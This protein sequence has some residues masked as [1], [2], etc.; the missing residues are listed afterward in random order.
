MTS[1]ACFVSPHGFGHAARASAVMEAIHDL[2]SS[3]R[4]EVFTSVPQWFFNESL[5]APFACHHLAT[6]IGLVQ[7][8]PLTEN[9]EATVERL[10]GFL[11]FAEAELDRLA[12][13]LERL[14]CRAVLC[15]ISPLG[16]ALAR[17]AALPSVLVENFTWD[18]IYA[19]YPEEP[20]LALFGDAMA[21]LNSGSTLHIQAG[22]PCRPDPRAIAVA[23]ISRR[24]RQERARVRERLGV[25]DS[26]PL[27]LLTMGGIPWSYRGMAP[28]QDYPH[29]YFVVPGAD[30]RPC[31][32]GRLV[33][34]PHHSAFYHPDLVHAADVAVGKLGYSTVAEV[35]HS[36]ATFGFVERPRFPESP[37]LADF[38]RSQMHGSEIAAGEFADNTWLHHLDRLLQPRIPPPHPS[39]GAAEA[40]RHIVA[41]LRGRP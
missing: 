5:T 2:D 33:A 15:D 7:R 31:R 32:R 37:V 16:L 14:G 23:P 24:P 9:L 11:P 29:A 21:E 3:I 20:R 6:D 12:T 25:P 38:V 40:S 26:A 36:R 4:F 10:A 39:D 35:Y 19:G 30:D 18:W 8:D 22:P 28:L 27:V 34:L 13:T 1:I 41:L 17:H